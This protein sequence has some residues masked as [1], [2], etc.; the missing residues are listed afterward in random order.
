[1]T[2]TQSDMPLWTP[3]ALEAATGGT[4][5]SAPKPI[6]GASIDTRSLQPFGVGGPGEHRLIVGGVLDHGA[7]AGGAIPRAI[8]R[9][10]HTGTEAAR[11][12]LEQMTAHHK[13]AVD[14]A[15]DEAKDGQNPQA[16]QLA[17]QVIA[18]QEAEIT[19]MEQMLQELPAT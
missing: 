8:V 17:E 16:V 7:A 19:E 4:L 6:T 1:M 3:E 2:Q 15:K 13:G 18:D 10:L 11:L 9:D 5:H 12:Y 14:M